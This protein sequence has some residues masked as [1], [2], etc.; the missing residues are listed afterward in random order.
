MLFRSLHTFLLYRLVMKTSN[1]W[2]SLA[3][4]PDDQANFM[5]SMIK[6]GGPLCNALAKTDDVL[7]KCGTQTCGDYDFWYNDISPS[8]Y[9]KLKLSSGQYLSQSYK[10]EG[11]GKKIVLSVGIYYFCSIFYNISHS[12]AAAY[13]GC[14]CNRT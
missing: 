13:G 5:D 1:L 9:D 2:G 10:Y 14:K 7:R 3:V 4:Y 11:K 12:T 6:I 8:S